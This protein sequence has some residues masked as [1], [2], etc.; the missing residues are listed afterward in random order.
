[1]NL[2]EYRDK[3]KNFKLNIVFFYSIGRS[4][5]AY[6]YQVF[7][8]K[9]WEPLQV[10][11]PPQGNVMVVHEKFGMREQDVQKL[12]LIKPTSKEGFTIQRNILKKIKNTALWNNCETY[13][14]TDSTFGRWCPYYII[15][16]FNYKAV[17]LKRNKDDVV[18]SWLRLYKKYT[19]KYGKQKG[20]DLIR[21]RFNSNYFNITDKYTLL[22]VDK[23][24][25]K[26]YST[27]ERLEWYYDETMAKWDVLRL[28]MHPKN[29]LETSYEQI[30]TV[31]G[32]KE[33]S[34]FIKLPFNYDLMKVKV[35]YN[36]YL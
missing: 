1:M 31:E 33:L 30:T 10:A 11:F 2:D 29:Y 7:G 14:T 27:K 9:K 25:W 26:S 32:L 4:G 24:L 34:D 28:Q 13:V 22:Y 19:T 6:L 17:L 12:K 8:H 16:N 23:K 18:N 3:K 21:K 5:T 36:E 15:K 20:K 35:N